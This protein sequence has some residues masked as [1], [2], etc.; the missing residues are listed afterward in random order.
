MQQFPYPRKSSTAHVYATNTRPSTDHNRRRLLKRYAPPCLA[1]LAILWLLTRLFPGAPPSTYVPPG[2]PPVV[3]VTTL[4]PKLPESHREAIKENRRAYAQR[5]GYATFFANTTDY[6]LMDKTPQSWATIPALRHAM[7]THPHTPWLWYLSS[8]SLIM[9][10]DRSLFTAVLNPATLEPLLI[11]D[12]PVVPP[13]SVI[14]TFSHLAPDAISLIISQDAEGLASG[15]ML[16]RTGEWAKFF[17]DAWFDPLYRSYNFQKAE[18]HALEHLVQWHGTIL[19]KLGLVPQRV[20]NSYTKEAK[21]GREQ[22]LYQEGDL[23]ANFHGCQRD[24]QRSCQEEM[25]PLISRQ[26]E[27]RELESGR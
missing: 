20:M 2:T 11:K 9:V 8:E 7:T 21:E 6:D 26:R 24:H 17:L 13:D 1:V 23:V 14:R 22:G 16:I 3:V 27:L 19:A 25:A 4:D 15:S 12:Q 10:P 18:G 5:H